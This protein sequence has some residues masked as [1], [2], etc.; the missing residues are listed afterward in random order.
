[1]STNFGETVSAAELWRGG[2]NGPMGGAHDQRTSVSVILPLRRPV[3]FI[4]RV[5]ERLRAAAAEELLVEVVLIDA[6][7]NGV[8]ATYEHLMEFVDVY[9]HQ[10][11]DTKLA[12]IQK[13]LA[14]AMGDVVVIWDV[15]SE[16]DPAY[17]LRAV[18]AILYGDADVVIGRLPS[19]KALKAL[20][21]EAKLSPHVCSAM[22]VEV[23]E[24]FELDELWEP[25][26]VS[27]LEAKWRVRQVV[28]GPHEV[29][30]TSSRQGPSTWR[31]VFGVEP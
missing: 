18:Q 25:R 6:S 30:H 13:G 26:L 28:I 21:G 22:R 17:L 19:R 15:Q 16:C 9:Q 3:P 27:R 5:V 31:D 4:E 12:S 10:P 7:P 1:M 14:N 23:L 24:G 2:E 29:N 20:G 11:R 8:I